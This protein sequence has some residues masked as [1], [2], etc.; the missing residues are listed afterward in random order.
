MKKVLLLGSGAREHAIAAAL[1]SSKE[2]IKLFV[3]GSSLNPGL[4]SLA[5]DYKIGNLTHNTAVLSF[6]TANEVDFAVIG[7]EAPLA[8][9]IVDV[10][11]QIGV[12]SVGP[13]KKLAAI[14]ISKSFAR[15][16]LS[17]YKINGCPAFK[18][19]SSP[20]GV[21]DYLEHLNGSFVIKPDGLTGGKGVKVAG[22][23]FQN[24][25]EG[26]KIIENLLQDGVK[27]VIEEKLIGQEFSL[28]SFS[29]G[30]H[31]IHLPIVQDHKR[32]LVGD[33][34]SNTGGMGSY[35]C[36]DFSLPFLTIDDL[37]EAQRIN[38]A[39]A[40]ALKKKCG[41]GYKGILYGGFMATKTGVKLIE[42][43]ARFGDPEAM[44]VLSLFPPRTFPENPAAD[45]LQVCQAII[46]G[47]L[48][49]LKLDL[50]PVAT[51]CKYVVPE[52]YPDQPVK[53]KVID[54]SRVDQKKVKVFY[55]A[56]D[57][58]LDGLYLTGSRAVALVGI[59]KDLFEAEKM[60]EEEIKKIKGPVF[61]RKDIGTRELVGKRVEMMKA[62]RS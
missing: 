17:E 39:V 57:Q 7:P 59:H 58:R 28:M 21:K 45:F 53:D 49:N 23:H 48:N 56:I 37:Q 3:F 9:G 47:N 31:L 50:Q 14:E 30:E 1:K 27:V 41:R 35:S 20:E 11:E 24:L 40:V 19:F 5:T 34:G 60:V 61:H 4:K 44:N 2:E 22:E 16:L 54:V 55:A 62:L 42:Y 46:D 25:N 18:I 51:V 33:L 29:D 43:N 36:A 6:A 10:L 32:A 15:E 8:E 12:P 26:L 52:G 38:T 13:T